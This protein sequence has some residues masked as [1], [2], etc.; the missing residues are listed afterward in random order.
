MKRISII[1]PIYNV[2]NK[3]KKCIDSLLLQD[4]NI[5]LILVN[6][7]S[8][9]NSAKM[10]KEYLAKYPNKIK[11]FEKENGGLSDARNF[12]LQ[13]ATGDYISFIDADDYITP[14]LYLDL[15]KYMNENYD[16]I[17]FKM[18]I[19]GENDELI[20]E[21]FTPTFY[22]KSGEEAFEILY[23]ADVMMVTACNYIYKREFWQENNFKYKK[24]LYHEDFG[25]TPLIILK[26]KKVASTDIGY[27]NYVQT[28]NSITRGNNK[29]IYK[30]AQDLLIHYDN[31]IE[32]IEKYDISKKSKENIKIYYTNAIILA[33]SNLNGEEQKQYIKE[34]K[35]RKMI[36]NIKARNLK[37]LIKKVI[38]KISIKW[39]LKLRKE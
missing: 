24:G 6:D 12:G 17:R 9:D 29:T 4:G 14:N 13:Y 18:N 30:R 36:N 10:A 2:E 5:Q 15:E 31:M 23:K 11:Y 20:N 28:S 19:V 39:Y 21:N 37:Q 16:L 34:I 38:L 26:A 1:V 32:E 8:T 3:L 27:Y 25:L 22:N 7:G 33:V 35:K